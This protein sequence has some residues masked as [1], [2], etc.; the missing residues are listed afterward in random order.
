MKQ[1]DSFRLDTVNHCLWRGEQRVTLTPK[2]F[3]LLRYLVEHAD[4]LVTQDEILEALWT[5]TYVNQEVI[6]K[7]ILE[8]RKALGDR[9]AQ[10][11]FVGTVPRRGYRFVAA[12]RETG[13]PVVAEASAA[14]V[15]VGRA[16][17]RATLERCMDSALLGS[18]QMMFVTGEPG[19]GKT[20]LVDV[21]H[22]HAAGRPK[23]RFARGQCVEG[24]GG[25]EAYYPVLESL[26]QLARGRGGAAVI[27]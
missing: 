9:A 17:A 23:L 10:P 12:V 27:E 15:M 4:R 25:K 8:I 16:A 7:Y 26:G 3:D 19:V 2:A 6:K 14:G 22:Q 21:F 18:R 20:T 1:F 13:I 24:F 11:A 5:G